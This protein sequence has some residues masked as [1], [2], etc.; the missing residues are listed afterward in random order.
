MNH[1]WDFGFGVRGLGVPGLL[2]RGL[3]VMVSGLSGLR[4]CRVLGSGL[5]FSPYI[6]K[7]CRPS[8]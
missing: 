7:G 6:L 3:G 8:I 1:S 2:F 5:E 4:L